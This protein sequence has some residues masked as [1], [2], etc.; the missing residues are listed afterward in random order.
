MTQVTA[1][2]SSLRI[3]PRKVRLVTDLIKG[4]EVTIAQQQLRHFAKRSA[5]PIG[6]LVKS[7]VAN[8]RHNAKIAAHENLYIKDIRVDEGRVLKRQMPRARGRAGLIKKRSSHI[9]LTIETRP[10]GK[11]DKK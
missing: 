2:L 4:L 1:T 7:A 3:A 10:L 11:G 9:A 6:K 8:A 5:E